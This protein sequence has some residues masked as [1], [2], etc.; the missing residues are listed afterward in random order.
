MLVKFLKQTRYEG[1]TVKPGDTADVPSNT[2]Q[3]WNKAG[4]AEIIGGEVEAS[5]EDI[6]VDPQDI[7]LKNRTNAVLKD[8]LEELGERIPHKVTKPNLI[9]AI[10]NARRRVQEGGED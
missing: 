6:A 9:S 3:R 8:M 10:N 7:P 5:S 1:E 4:I 2:T